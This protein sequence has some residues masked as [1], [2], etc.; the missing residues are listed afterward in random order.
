MRRGL[1]PNFRCITD[2]L[3][4]SI[5]A[6]FLIQTTLKIF[7]GELSLLRL[8]GFSFEGLKSGFIWTIFTYSI[9]HEG[10]LHLIFNLL[11]IHFISRNV[12]F[13]ISSKKYLYLF[14]VSSIC[15]ALFWV[16]FN[17]DM[18]LLLGASAFVMACLT[19][20]CMHRP[21]EPITFLLFFVLPV[22]IKPKFLLIGVLGLEVYGFLFGE[23]QNTSNIAHSAHLGGMAV[24]LLYSL[25]SFDF[26]N[27]PKFSFNFN[28]TNF[29]TSKP[30]HKS[31]N[32]TIRSGN[33]LD[34]Q[35]QIDKIL[36]K[37]N[38][39]GFGSLNETEK[40]MLEKAKTLFN[41]KRK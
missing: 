39:H 40:R 28:R 32:Y 26:L 12:E 25:T 17:S 19:Y 21:D 2:Y 15:G 41:D 4:L 18:G 35:I 33:D 34:A 16:T 37:I 8:T 6:T 30:I 1:S 5:I 7:D 23:L 24:G 10:A 36:D 13:I 20:F 29:P 22:K 27:L 14:F 38:E 9:L 11:G 3:I 31:K